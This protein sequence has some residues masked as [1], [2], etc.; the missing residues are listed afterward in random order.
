MSVQSVPNEL[1]WKGYELSSDS[2]WAHSVFFGKSG[3]ELT[4][5]FESDPVD[6]VEN[7]FRIPDGAFPYYFLQFG[8][9]AMSVVHSD[10]ISKSDAASAFLNYFLAVSRERPHAI[11]QI[12][13]LLLNVADYISSHQDD[14]WA[15]EAIY[16]SFLDIYEEIKR[17]LEGV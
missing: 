15:D 11:R 7:I 4:K 6:A 17:I 8:R 13:S 1:D 10:D 16:G 5:I 14:Y 2:T 12:A 9:Y 3:S